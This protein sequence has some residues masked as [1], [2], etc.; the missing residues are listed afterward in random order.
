MWTASAPSHGWSWTSINFNT[1]RFCLIGLRMILPE[2]L[3]SALM[4]FALSRVC[5]TNMASSTRDRAVPNRPAVIKGSGRVCTA[6]RPAARRPGRGDPD[7]APAIRSIG[8]T[9]RESAAY[10]SGHP[11]RTRVALAILQVARCSGGGAP[12]Y[13]CPLAPRGLEAVPDPDGSTRPTMYANANTE[14]DSP[15]GA[16]NGSTMS[17]F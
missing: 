13:V 8:R 3:C 11:R 1:I 12:R 4:R 10:R 16:R 9:P 14:S 17:F 5:V 15:H 2:L 6:R 7:A